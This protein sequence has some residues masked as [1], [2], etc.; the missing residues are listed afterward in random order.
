M[1]AEIK[2]PLLRIQRYQKILSFQGWSRLKYN[3]NIDIIIYALFA[4]HVHG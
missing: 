4:T 2:Y 1:D 3:N